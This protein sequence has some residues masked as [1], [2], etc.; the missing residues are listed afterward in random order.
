MICFCKNKMNEINIKTGKYYICP[1]CNYLKKDNILNDSAQKERYDMHV[2]DDG[3]KKY[4]NNVFLKIEKYLNKGKSIDYGCG[5]IHYLRDILVDN[6][7]DCDYF[8]LFYYNHKINDKYD[9]IILIEVFEHI[10]DIYSF[11]IMLKGMLNKNGRIIIMTQAI[12]DNFENWWYL[13][14]STHVSF[15]NYKTMDVMSKMINMSLE[16]DK[17]ASLFVLSSIE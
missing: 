10:E 4:M 12:P 1:S 16:Y 9:N 2:C 6:N 3:Y 17:E 13:R 15:V 11:L 5:K 7:Y 14:D 8:D